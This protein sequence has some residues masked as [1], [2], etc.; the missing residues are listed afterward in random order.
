MDVDLDF[1]VDIVDNVDINIRNNIPRHIYERTNYFET[2]SETE[3]FKRF[4]LQ[5]RT[6]LQI[7]ERIE[8]ELEYPHNR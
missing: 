3:F 6:V 1:L 4:R 5:K 2:Y 7:L 8:H